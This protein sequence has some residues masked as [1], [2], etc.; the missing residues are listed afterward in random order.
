VRAI[1]LYERYGCVRTG[2]TVFD[3]E[4]LLRLDL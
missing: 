2:D 4:V 3:D 1:P